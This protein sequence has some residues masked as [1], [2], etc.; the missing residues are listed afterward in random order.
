MKSSTLSSFFLFRWLL[1]LHL[2]IAS[3][4]ASCPAFRLGSTSCS[5]G[6]FSRSSIS[7]SCAGDGNVSVQGTVT[8]PYSFEDADV[9]FVPCIRTTGFCFEEYTQQGG[10]ICDLISTTDGSECG[11][12][13]KYTIHEEFDVPQEV[14]E[15]S[16]AMRFVTIKVLIDDQEACT[17]NATTASSSAFMATGMA[18]LFAV[19]GLSLYFVR[20][21]RR[22][23]LVLEGD[24]LGEDH[25]FVTMNDLSPSVSS[26][27]IRG[28]LSTAA[29]A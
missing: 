1:A 29:F 23:L 25:G 21:R 10:S 3:S 9:T 4:T 12:A 7:A 26:I 27:G 16:W 2:L 6:I 18:S 20:R 13:G 8:A 24:G 17:Q 5:S 22:P 14:T 11:S 19:G 15:N 28:A